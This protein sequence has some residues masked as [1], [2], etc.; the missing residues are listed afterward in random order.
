MFD[1][2]C[3]PVLGY[4]CPALKVL[5]SWSYHHDFQIC[6]QRTARHG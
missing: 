6:C 4:P 1:A 2:A 3:G 5:L